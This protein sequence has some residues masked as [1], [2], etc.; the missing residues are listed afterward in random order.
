MNKKDKIFGSGGRMKKRATHIGLSLFLVAVSV[1]LIA[2]PEASCKKT[3][4]P[5][6][7]LKRADECRRSLYR[8][9]QKKRYRHNWSHC[10][11]LYRTLYTR[12]PKSEQA[13]WALYHSAN[14]FTKLYGYSGKDGDL[15]KAIELYKRVVNEYTHHRLADD[16]QYKIGVVYYRHRKDYAQAYVE[17]LKVDITFPSGDMR[18]RAKVMLDR[19]SKILGKKERQKVKAGDVS[20]SNELTKVKDIRHWSTPGYTRVVIDLD[21][22]IKYRSHRLKKD[23]GI[24]KPER[25]YVD[26][27]NAYVGS[28][29]EST[30]PIKDGLLQR[31]RAGQYNKNTVRVVLDINSI[32]SY[33]TFHLHG[34]F[35]IVVDVRGKKR[36]DDKGRIASRVKSR[37]VRKGV[38]KTNQPDK[39]I[40]LAGQLGLNVRRIVIDPGH[41]G[42]DPGCHLPGG[43]KEKDIVLSLAKLLARKIRARLQCEV[44]L[45][46][47]KDVFL[48]LEQRTAF[49]NTKEADLFISLHINAYK[50]RGVYGIETYFLNMATDKRAV[51]LAARENATSEKNMRD[52]KCKAGPF[53]CPDRR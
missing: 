53:L 51:M 28:D 41:G 19:L 1:W 5:Q 30:I 38:R 20:K 8:S 32:G 6:M 3:S 29:I 40:S 48:S 4:R 23:P 47:T 10:I 18:P 43:I 39:T 45:T 35:R 50:Q 49:A 34:P 36:L 21:R 9:A 44:F 46:R 2:P 33:K 11:K 42:K 17:F 37:P 52:L 16:S 7:L 25:L 22:P 13:A 26:L 12:Y 31:A 15:D 14:M 27:K 24:K